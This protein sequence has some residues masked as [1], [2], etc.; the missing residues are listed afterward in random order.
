MRAAT[1]RKLAMRTLWHVGKYLERRRS[2]NPME[3]YATLAALEIIVRKY[4]EVLNDVP[5]Q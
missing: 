4:N 2:K 1:P 3:F 5:R